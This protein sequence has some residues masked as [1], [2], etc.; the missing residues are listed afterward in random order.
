LLRNGLF[1][2]GGAV[3]RS[4]ISL[5][6]IPLLI[7][8]VGLREYGVWSLACAVLSFMTLSESGLSVAAT[9]FL[10]TD[11]AKY[12]L[13][14]ARRTLTFVLVS[15]V[16]VSVALGL[17][18]WLA[19]PWMVRP[20]AGFKSMERAEAGRALK[21]AGL[22]L[23]VFILERT[24]IGIEQSFDRYA[25]MNCLEIVQSFLT[26]VGLVVVAWLGGRT[27]AM[28][29]WQVFAWAIPLAGHGY[30]VCRLLRN[31]NLGF[32][33]DINKGRQIFRY[34]IATWTAALG[35][36]AFGQGDRVV[37]GAVL[38]APLLGIYSA[39]TNI[40][41]KINSFSGTA[42]QPLLSGNSA[43]AATH[44][45]PEAII[46]PATQLNALIAFEAGVLLYVLAD[47][48][49]SLMV[50]GATAGQDILGL[51]VA[52]VVYA[53]YSLNA[54]GYFVLFSLGDAKT[55]A[56]VVLTSAAVSL[57]LIFAG[58]RYFG[59]LGAI[60]GN[61]GYLGT[62]FLTVV[63][64]RKI[65]IPLRRYLGW[66]A[67]PSLWLAVAFVVG[68]AFRGHFV[69][70]SVFVAVQ[71]AVMM[72]WF[73]QEHGEFMCGEVGFV[74]PRQFGRSQST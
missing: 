51:Q 55:N 5:I 57:V 20:I 68:I 62:W 39:I 64:L 23:S 69:W 1:N 9:V 40:T 28:M 56:I 73:L 25:V 65:R 47:R 19:G 58:A 71:A 54:P 13:R 3:G 44:G 27:I 52:A 22:A 26:N 10:S 6:T 36:A 2:I 43:D 67:W 74:W 66:M 37:V 29:K 34:S 33:W 14:E 63:S 42:V 46:R 72:L 45:S 4:V 12:D 35:S 17:L 32:E 48:V 18:L 7:R 59:L 24:L 15:A 21:I 31:K 11:L 8:I 38:G 41:T 49:M 50:P 16:A 70:R 60:A 53:L 61:L 30:F